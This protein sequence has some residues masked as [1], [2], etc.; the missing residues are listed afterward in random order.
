MKR[1][2]VLSLAL[3]TLCCFALNGITVRAEGGE[4]ITLEGH[5]QGDYSCSGNVEK[6]I[7]SGV[8]MDKETSLTINTETVLE[9]KDGTENNIF[10]LN[11]ENTL[12]ITGGG[13]LH[14]SAGAIALGADMTFN[15]TGEIDMDGA[16]TG[17]EANITI[18]SGTVRIRATTE[19]ATGISCVQGN[20]VLNGGVLDVVSDSVGI[21]SMGDLILNGGD[22]N[23]QSGKIALM[24]VNKNGINLSA[25][26]MPDGTAINTVDT[27]AGSYYTL[28]N[29]KTGGT[30]SDYKESYEGGGS[31]QEATGE[32][33]TKAKETKEQAVEGDQQENKQEKKENPSVIIIMIVVVSIAVVAGVFAVVTQSKH[34]SDKKGKKRRK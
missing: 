3:V 25:E 8:E 9:I 15:H 31:V 12:N 33:A 16:L 4:V 20:V 19:G 26:M 6:L 2:K 29:E 14:I 23:V 24:A 32:F 17:A 21:A 22:V 27:E 34:K 5:I 1:R 10:F 7:L 18:N 28:V 30:I 11:G 13:K